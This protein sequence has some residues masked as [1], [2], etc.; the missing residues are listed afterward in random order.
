MLMLVIWRALF[1]TMGIE[2]VYS[3]LHACTREAQQGKISSVVFLLKKE[4][5][6]KPFIHLED[7]Y[8]QGISE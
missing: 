4:I 8:V 1:E 7:I 2:H 5:L 6:Q 3:F